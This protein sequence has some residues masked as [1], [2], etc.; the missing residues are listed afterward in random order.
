MR[1]ACCSLSVPEKIDE[2]LNYVVNEPPEDADDKIRYLYPYKVT[3][4][5]HHPHQE[6]GSAA[7]DKVS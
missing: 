2:M 6:E 3:A 1:D 5:S 7:Q 4:P